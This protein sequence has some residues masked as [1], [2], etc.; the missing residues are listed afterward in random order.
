VY[1]P[2][3]RFARLTDSEGHF[4]YRLPNFTG[5]ASLPGAEVQNQPRFMSCCLQARKPGFLSDPNQQQGAEIALG[6]E[7]T[8]VL[9]P[10]GLIKGR[11][12]L[13]SSDAAIG[14][15]VEI[16]WRQVQDGTLHWVR[17]ASARANSNGEFRFSELRPG[18]YK[19]LT[20]ELMDP[21]HP[22]MLGGRQLYGFP[23][24]YFPAP[25]TSVRPVRLS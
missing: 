14:I 6:S 10:E 19:I 9:I 25:W 3:N 1:T 18:E 11:V 12:S 5:G 20:R 16:F 7:P 21:I 24:V 4:D 17:G 8:V 23:P 2:D 22:P 15:G 13:P